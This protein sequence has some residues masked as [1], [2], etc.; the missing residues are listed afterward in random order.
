M[1]L[2]MILCLQE[3]KFLFDSLAVLGD[4]EFEGLC[5]L[6]R[7]LKEESRKKS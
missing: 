3:I 7:P 4:G 5:L 1:Y 2:L 6:W